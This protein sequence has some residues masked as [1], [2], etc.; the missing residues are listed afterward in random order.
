M[1][2][3]G[4]AYRVRADASLASRMGGRVVEGTG[5]EN[6]CLACGGPIYQIKSN[7]F[8]RLLG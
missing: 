4:N 1:S 6:C 7:I 2:N 5:L 8:I 3:R